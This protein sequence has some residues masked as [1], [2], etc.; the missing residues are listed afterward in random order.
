MPAYLEMDCLFNE[1]NREINLFTHLNITSVGELL[2]RLP[3]EYQ[4]TARGP[5]ADH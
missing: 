3:R 4:S 5:I 2:K 1:N